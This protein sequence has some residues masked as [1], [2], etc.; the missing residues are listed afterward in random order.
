[1]GKLKCCNG[2]IKMVPYL[3]LVIVWMPCLARQAI[4]CFWWQREAKPSQAFN[5]WSNHDPSLRQS[6][7]YSVVYINQCIINNPIVKNLCVN[8]LVSKKSKVVSSDSQDLNLTVMY[9]SWCIN[10]YVT[11]LPLFLE[12]PLS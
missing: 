1:M 9:I 4:A 3:N 7:H 12:F 6:S 5:Q 10:I 11:P 8:L 2:E